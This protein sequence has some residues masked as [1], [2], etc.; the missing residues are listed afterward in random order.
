MQGL[1]R[2]ACISWFGSWA[3]LEY[4]LRLHEE[5]HPYRC[6]YEDCGREFMSPKSLKKHQR[7]WHNIDGKDGNTE[8]L[9]RNRITK[10]QSKYKVGVPSLLLKRRRNWKK[11]TDSWRRR[12]S[13]IK[14]SSARTRRWN[15]SW[16]LSPATPLWTTSRTSES[17]WFFCRISMF[18]S[19]EKMTL[20]EMTPIESSLNDSILL[21]SSGINLIAPHLSDMTSATLQGIT[22]TNIAQSIAVPNMNNIS[23]HEGLH[24]NSIAFSKPMPAPVPQNTML[25][26]Q[27]NVNS[28]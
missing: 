23:R 26:P 19:E 8:S 16:H 13:P 11:S 28:L 5:P 1:L 9:L 15:V 2:Y 22:T 4:H 12:W 14:C 17:I 25:A 10:M 20:L 21:P 6:T 3:S 7:L 18:R 27:Q 24:L